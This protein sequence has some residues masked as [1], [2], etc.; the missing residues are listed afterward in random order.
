MKIIRKYLPLLVVALLLFPLV[1]KAVHD[2]GHFNEEHCELKDTHYCNVEHNCSLCDYVF[3]SP[4]N[5]PIA[6]NNISLFYQLV[7]TL[8]SIIVFKAIV[9]QKFT[10]KLRGPPF[11]I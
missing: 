4:S 8:V 7:F 5:Q 2:R 11:T 6:Q 3:S 1:E 9:S 10:F